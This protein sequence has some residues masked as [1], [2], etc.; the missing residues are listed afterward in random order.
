MLFPEQL[1]NSATQEKKKKKVETKADILNYLKKKKL[2]ESKWNHKTLTTNS[3]TYQKSL[4]SN[5]FH[6]NLLIAKKNIIL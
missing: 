4:K 1:S 6:I 5:I 3:F 2:N